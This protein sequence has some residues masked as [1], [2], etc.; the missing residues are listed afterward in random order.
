M[1]HDDTYWPSHHHFTWFYIIIHPDKYTCT[2]FL[3]LCQSVVLLFD[4]LLCNSSQTLPA[5]I[6]SSCQVSTKNKHVILWNSVL[7]GVYNHQNVC[8]GRMRC[9]RIVCLCPFRFCNLSAIC[10]RVFVSADDVK[11]GFALDSRRSMVVTQFKNMCK[12]CEGTKT[13]IQLPCSRTYRGPWP[14]DLCAI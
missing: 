7:K 5:S 3:E 8:Y 13:N 2:C 12:L 6:V 14:I 1:S 10:V 4:C 11:S 9:V